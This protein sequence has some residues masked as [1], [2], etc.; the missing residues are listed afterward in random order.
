MKQNSLL[1]LGVTSGMEA[2]VR[3]V[4]ILSNA[5][6]LIIGTLLLFYILINLPRYFRVDSLSFSG[7][8]PFLIVGTTGFCLF[9]NH[10]HRYR[11]SKLIFILCWIGFVTIIPYVLYGTSNQ[12]YILHP[13]YCM[14]T[15]MMVHLL[16]SFH[17]E[18]TLY[19]ILLIGVWL[20]ILFSVEFVSLF[21]IPQPE[22]E[23]FRRGFFGWRILFFMFAAFFNASMMYV[24]YYNHRFYTSLE[25][26]KEKVNIQN[27]ALKKLTAQLEGTVVEQTQ[28]LL[29]QNETLTEYTAFNSH[30]L[31][32]PVSRILGL[33]NLLALDID[34]EE[35]K[36][37]R[38]LL[39]ISVNELDQII[40][41]MNQKLV[42]T[43]FDQ[44]A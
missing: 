40:K 7:M 24:L 12:D 31:R 32:A 9:L 3:R 36:K 6:Y 34:K 30:I 22:S 29:K 23:L 33:L 20:L 35:E 37:I 16:F 1:R 2:E 5:V 13:I 26:Q 17:R 11:L 18:R 15:S 25:E 43:H 39:S 14:I 21:K 27:E 19:L 41:E 38:E 44:Q 10:L 8:V 28:S 42:D 4:T